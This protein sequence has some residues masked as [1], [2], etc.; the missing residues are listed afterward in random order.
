M[1]VDP[2]EV[3]WVSPA[4]GNQGRK[5][6]ILKRTTDGGDAEYWSMNQT[7]DFARVNLG[8]WREVRKEKLP[9]T[10]MT[11]DDMPEP[12]PEEK[13]AIMDRLDDYIGGRNPP[14]AAT[15]GERSRGGALMGDP[16]IRAGAR[17]EQRYT[18][19][20][21]R[22]NFMR[23]ARE[24]GPTGLVAG[25]GV[26]AGAGWK[27][28]KYG[29]VALAAARKGAEG[30]GEMAAM[31]REVL[32]WFGSGKEWASWIW[33]SLKEWCLWAKDEY[34]TVLLVLLFVVL[35]YK[36]FFG[37][38]EAA[39][40]ISQ[41][42]DEEDQRD[43]EEAAA[44]ERR[45]RERMR[46]DQVHHG[47]LR[48]SLRRRPG[49]GDGAGGG[50]GG[51]VLADDGDYTDSL[52]RRSDD[53]R[54]V[55]AA[56]AEPKKSGS[57]SDNQETMGETIARLLKRA[58]SPLGQAVKI[59]KNFRVVRP[60]GMPLGFKV[61][62]GAEKIAEIY[63]EGG[64]ALQVSRRMKKEKGLEKCNAWRVH[65]GLSEVVDTFVL[66]DADMVPQIINTE[67]LERLMR[68]IYGLE[69]VMEAVEETSHWKGD[70]KN[71]RTR[72]DLLG[73]YHA[74]EASRDGRID[75]V[76]DEV[77]VKLQKEALFQKYLE[78]AKKK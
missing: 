30:E 60:W 19:G 75:T 78:K 61:R 58:V 45:H 15:R 37:P 68:W 3:R 1:P 24:F 48:D 26:G 77:N 65:E 6:F 71:L 40:Q 21:R 51:G 53:Y 18:Q 25:A 17:G 22:K 73:E 27:L 42:R 62:M 74:T 47:Q 7:G 16:M 8:R 72:W 32:L 4:Q 13:V 29:K 76:D 12:T 66:K 59:L 69:M 2:F 64:T 63:S 55:G 33:A 11:Y 50:A 35:I 23:R 9:P 28:W 5:I 43:R 49:D 44:E 10:E 31:L 41:F 38:A 57:S 54:A 46:Q 36:W 14:R 39:H 67:G 70:A 20:R 52:R 34:D 56:D